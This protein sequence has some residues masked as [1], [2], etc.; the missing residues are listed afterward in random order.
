[1]PANERE[2]GVQGQHSSTVVKIGKS[3][4]NFK[5]RLLEGFLK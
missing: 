4:R 3:A 5:S 1:M 2:F